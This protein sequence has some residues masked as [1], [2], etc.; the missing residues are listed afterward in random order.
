[1]A[2]ASILVVSVIY[3]FNSFS[4]YTPAP[5]EIRKFCMMFATPVFSYHVFF[6]NTT[7]LMQTQLE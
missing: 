1:M 7:D 4:R 6:K 5:T 3:Q 2:D